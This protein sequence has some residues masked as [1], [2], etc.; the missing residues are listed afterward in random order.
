MGLATVSVPAS[1]SNSNEIRRRLGHEPVLDAIRGIA[2]LLVLAR[3]SGG[4]LPGGALGVDLFFVLSGFL[5]TSLLLNEWSGSGRL[6]LGAFYR[7]RALRLFP[8]LFA[9][10]AVFVVV[11]SLLLALGRSSAARF[12]GDVADAGLGVAYVLNFVLAASGS[13]PAD[14]LRP[15]WSLAQEEQFYLVWPVLLLVML[16]TRLSPRTIAFV[17]AALFAALVSYRMALAL[18]GAPIHRLWFAPDTHADPI[19][20]GCLAGVAYSYGLLRRVPSWLPLTL[21]VPAAL[22]LATLDTYDRVLYTVP[23]PLFSVTCAVLL[24]AVLTTPESRLAWALNLRPLRALGR[25]SYG[26]YLWQL[27]IFAAFGWV[28]GLPITFAVAL[29]SFR[30]IEKPFLRL[31]AQG[32]APRTAPAPALAPAT[33]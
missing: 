11:S 25:I 17:L 4:I 26:L 18:S 31:K 16:R 14:S 12:G 30:Y 15:L 3:H 20:L 6:S 9:M 10:L 28:L 1:C 23:L 33:P 5:I 19:V 7:R 13:I 2:I 22:T 24:L 27:P 29:I 32:R 8:A 21:L